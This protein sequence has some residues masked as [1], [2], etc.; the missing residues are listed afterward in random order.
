M[1]IVPLLVLN[2]PKYV[3]QE[4]KDANRYNVT[5]QSLSLIQFETDKIY[6]TYIQKQ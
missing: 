2:R 1:I 6:K 4:K 3:N 5:G